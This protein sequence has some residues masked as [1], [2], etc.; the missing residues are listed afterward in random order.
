MAECVHWQRPDGKTTLVF[1]DRKKFP[2]VQ[3]STAH[4]E[5]INGG[6]LEDMAMKKTTRGINKR[7]FFR[8]GVF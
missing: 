4:T 3:G 6:G 2:C 5:L 1:T 8:Q 7:T